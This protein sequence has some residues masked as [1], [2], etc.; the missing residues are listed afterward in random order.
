MSVAI[1]SGVLSLNCPRATGPAFALPVCHEGVVGAV[2]GRGAIPGAGAQLPG[3]GGDGS[4]LGCQ[5]SS[6]RGGF[7]VT[8]GGSGAGVAS[9]GFCRRVGGGGVWC[10]AGGAAPLGGGP[11]PTRAQKA[12]E[13]PPAVSARSW[14][15]ERSPA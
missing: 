2:V 13:A 8:E 14:A 7:S 5:C 3:G 10:W 15:A 4:V 1:G 6:S 9:S 12:L 11:P